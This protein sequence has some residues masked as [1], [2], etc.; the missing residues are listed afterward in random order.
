MGN[1]I[2]TGLYGMSSAATDAGLLDWLRTFALSGALLVILRSTV[3]RGVLAFAAVMT[4]AR[5]A[6]AQPMAELDLEQRPRALE[7]KLA[8]EQSQARWYA[9]G[10]PVAVAE[11]QP[12]TLPWVAKEHAREYRR[13]FGGFA[14]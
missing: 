6:T 8:A 7:T 11:V 4:L 3:G 12:W 1:E 9:G 14:F 10:M 5:V 2:L 13:E